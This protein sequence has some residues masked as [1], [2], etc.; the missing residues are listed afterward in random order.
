VARELMA[1]SVTSPSL[2]GA[3]VLIY[4][5]CM[6]DEYPDLWREYA[7]GREP[8][9]VC[10]QEMH[11][12]RVGFKVATIMLKARPRSITVLTMN[13]S[14]HCLQLHFAVEQ[15]RQLTGF[16]GE[17]RHVVVEKGEAFEVSPEAIKAARH[18]AT[19]ESLIRELSNASQQ[20]DI[21]KS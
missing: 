6:V 13:G 8:L 14:P 19:V 20:R 4:S 12:D 18:L 17:V 10:L 2:R 21:T 9:S 11:M 3:D 15:A 7:R 5:K 16:E 1:T